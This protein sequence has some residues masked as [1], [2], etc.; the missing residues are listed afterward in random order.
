MYQGFDDDESDAVD[1]DGEDE[2]DSDMDDDEMW[3]DVAE[4]VEFVTGFSAV[5]TVRI[6][7]MSRSHVTFKRKMKFPLISTL[8]ITNANYSDVCEMRNF[9]FNNTELQKLILN[10][11]DSNHPLS[12]EL[13]KMCMNNMPSV[14]VF[15]IK[16]AGK[17]VCVQ[18]RDEIE[19]MMLLMEDKAFGVSKLKISN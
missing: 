17:G 12:L 16:E 3:E 6:D 13:W 9:G 18:T 14:I 4:E 10:Y 2:I 7:S 5:T 8:E 1:T 11:K 19:S 15:E